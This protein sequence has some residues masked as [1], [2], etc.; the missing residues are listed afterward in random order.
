MTHHDD[1]IPPPLHRFSA[2]AL[3][4]WLHDNW[5]A[6]CDRPRI[7]R[8]RWIRVYEPHDMPRLMTYIVGGAG[9]IVGFIACLLDMT[10]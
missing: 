3:S 5:H 6:W 2:A 4:A 10:R 7:Y 8:A 9:A 1:H